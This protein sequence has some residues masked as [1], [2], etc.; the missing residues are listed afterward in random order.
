MRRLLALT[1][2]ALLVGGC[3]SGAILNCTVDSSYTRIH[4]AANDC[5]PCG[6]D[7]VPQSVTADY[8]LWSC[9]KPLPPATAPYLMTLPKPHAIMSPS[10]AYLEPEA[11]MGLGCNKGRELMKLTL[12]AAE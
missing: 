8:Q 1:V 11:P 3:Q 9:S 4:D 10:N 2:V 7:V 5:S 6:H 12:D